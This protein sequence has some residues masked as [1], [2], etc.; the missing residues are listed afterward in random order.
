MTDTEKYIAIK[1]FKLRIL[2]SEGKSFE[3]L[4]TQVMRATYPD[5][6]QV[7]PQGRFG[8]RKN[9]GFIPNQ[10][11]FYQVYAPENLAS[12]EDRAIQKL[13]EDFG[14]LKDYWPSIGYKLKTFNYVIN[15]K[16]KGI[17]VNVTQSLYQLRTSNPTIQFAVKDANWLVELFRRLDD[18]YM[19]DI[20]GYIPSAQCEIVSLDMLNEA[21][22][23]IMKAPVEDVKP[24][25][26]SNPDMI[27]KITFNGLTECVK[28]LLC[29]KL[30][31]V[32]AIDDYF[33]NQGVY[34][35]DELRNHF[36]TFY[37]EA[38]KE[39]NSSGGTPDD[40]FFRILDKALFANRT[41]AVM[42]AVLSLM[43]Y[44]FEC[45]DIFESPEK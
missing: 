13:K 12:A 39:V 35:K 29:S 2:E 24:F 41:K 8:D 14:G 20:V 9:D 21:I 16:F 1:F 40:I 10:G 36:N 30:I 28:L 3:D 32:G 31:N 15:D 37:L 4:F 44:Y 33:T 18:E 34:S 38:R 45:C 26:P 5:F 27:Q 23:Y 6:V 22:E 43:A 42:E 7:K 19:N 11:A 25:I 17:P